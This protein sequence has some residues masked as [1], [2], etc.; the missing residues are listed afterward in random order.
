MRTTIYRNVL[1]LSLCHGGA[2]TAI[3]RV[4][5]RCARGN[6]E[7]K[8]KKRGSIWEWMENEKSRKETA[9]MT[10][11]RRGE[12]YQKERK[13]EELKVEMDCSDGEFEYDRRDSDQLDVIAIKIHRIHLENLRNSRFSAPPSDTKRYSSDKGFSRIIDH[14]F[15]QH[16]RI[17]RENQLHTDELRDCN[18]YKIAVLC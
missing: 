16:I 12:I 18:A 6:S 7:R 2:F 4:V 5:K 11:G 8:W 3:K 14:G 1:D 9:E 17:E 10:G 13:D 15:R